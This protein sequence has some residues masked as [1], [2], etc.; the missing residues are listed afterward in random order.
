MPCTN[1][2][3]ML[4]GRCACGVRLSV[5]PLVR[6]CP[7]VTRPLLQG[8]R[9]Q[10]ISEYGRSSC[11][12]LTSTWSPSVSHP[13]LTDIPPDSSL[14]RPEHVQRRRVPMHPIR[15]HSFET[16]LVRSLVPPRTYRSV[17]G[18]PPSESEV[19]MR[20]VIIGLRVINPSRF[21]CATRDSR[22]HLKIGHQSRDMALVCRR[23][24]LFAT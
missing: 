22:A 9:L 18:R 23:S 10:C 4:A 16:I 17:R 24:V 20:Q 11:S 21:F 3:T 2:V 15:R 14:Y 13:V 7:P 8:I 1:L 5:S 12:F 6:H 19:G